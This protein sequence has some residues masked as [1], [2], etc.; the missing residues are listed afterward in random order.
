VK[1]LE[2]NIPKA[3][4]DDLSED[5]LK[6]YLAIMLYKERFLWGKRQNWLVYRSAISC[7]NWVSIKNPSPT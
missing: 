6:L 4:V 1:W 7:M 5:E 3:L 2:L